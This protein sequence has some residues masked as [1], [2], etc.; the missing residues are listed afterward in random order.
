MDVSGLR[1]RRAGEEVRAGI[2]VKLDAETSGGE[3]TVFELTMPPGARSAAHVHTREQEVFIVLEGL[4]VLS[5]EEGETELAAGDT[6]VLPRDVRHSFS[7]GEAGVRFL[8]ATTPGGLERFF[9]EIDAGVAPGE[10]AAN[11]GL[12]FFDP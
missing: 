6:A 1:V 7:A 11:A 4:L 12:T 2:E 10:A 5:T 8:I 9:R 3:L